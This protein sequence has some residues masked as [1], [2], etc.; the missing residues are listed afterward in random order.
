MRI[1]I[2]GTAFPFRGGLAAF[3]E[4]LAKQFIEDGHE[5]TMYTFTLQYPNFLFPGKTQ[6][7]S[8]A[9]P[10]GL[11]IIP[12]INSINP[13]NWITVG[14]KIRK[15]KFDSVVFC[16]WMSFIAPCFGTIARCLQK[17][18]TKRIALVHNMIPHEKSI[19]DILF[20]KYFVRAMDGFTAMSDVVKEDITKLG[21]AQKPII[22]T[23]HP[24][25]DHFGAIMPREEAIKAINLDPKTRYI[26]F[27]G[28]IRSYKGLDLLLKAFADERLRKLP[29]KLLVAGEFYDDEQYYLDLITQ[30]QLSEHVFICADYI[31]DSEV[32]EWFSSADLIVQPYRSATQSG[33][34]QIAYHFEKPML[35][36]NVG[37]LSEIVPHGKAGYV[38][39]PN[40]KEIAD[41]ILDFYNNNRQAAF[42]KGTKEEKKKY[43]WNVMSQNISSLLKEI[44]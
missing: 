23:P 16:Y 5:V 7:S 4:R 18:K 41:S 34:S 29:L 39:E 28:L 38:V 3:N 40:I 43:Q 13:F 33:I 26:L 24:L 25:Y 1:A 32:K 9:A 42:E 36:T 31:P 14:R 19:L 12:C 8:E 2:V 20:P 22:V 21:A 10:K 30:N 6:F 35:V 15:E 44:Q 37:G 17:K 27:F 11:K